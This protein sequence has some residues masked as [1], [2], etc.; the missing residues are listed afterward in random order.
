VQTR[1]PPASLSGASQRLGQLPL[2]VRTPDQRC[3]DKQQGVQRMPSRIGIVTT[4]AISLP[5]L[6]ALRRS[7]RQLY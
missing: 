4:A 1:F 7:D 2:D 5:R 6:T 3:K